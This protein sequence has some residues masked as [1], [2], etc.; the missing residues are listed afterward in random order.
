MHTK[1]LS[2]AAFPA[3]LSVLAIGSMALLSLANTG[4]PPGTRPS[5]PTSFLPAPPPPDSMHVYDSTLT[6]LASDFYNNVDLGS[7]VH[8]LFTE[9]ELPWGTLAA[10]LPTDGSPKHGLLID[11]GLQ[12]DSLRFGFRFTPLTATGTPG[13]FIY[14]PPDTVLDF[15]NATLTPVPAST[16][17]TAYQY[18]TSSSTAYF[19]RV[20]ISHKAGVFDE[21][22]QQTDAHADMMAWEDEV[23][24]MYQANTTFHGDSVLYLVVRAIARRDAGGD[25]RHRTCYHLRLR[26]RGSTSGPHRDLLDNSFDRNALLRMHGCDFGNLCPPDCNTYVEPPR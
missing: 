10:Q 7:G 9:Q 14:T 23:K 2:R 18:A 26:P 17:R 8:L 1:T 13:Q 25:L 6:R 24:A 15:W 19:S 12:G 21:V 11:Y 16:W 22:S 3:A 5:P 20:R 4:A